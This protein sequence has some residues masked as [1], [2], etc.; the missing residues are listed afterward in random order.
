MI[1]SVENLTIV[2]AFIDRLCSGSRGPVVLS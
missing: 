1:T 2:S